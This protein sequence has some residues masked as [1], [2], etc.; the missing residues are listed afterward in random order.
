M[1]DQASTFL[2]DYKITEQSV[3][4]LLQDLIFSQE[5]AIFHLIAMTCLEYQHRQS[6]QL[7]RQENI[8]YFVLRARLWI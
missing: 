7:Q 5:S 6:M 3:L 4:T 8:V 2:C 1:N